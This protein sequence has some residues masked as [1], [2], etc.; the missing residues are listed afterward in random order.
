[1]KPRPRELDLLDQLW[2]LTDASR[3]HCEAILQDLMELSLPQFL[4]LRL[5]DESARVSTPSQV[6]RALGC[7]RA[8]ASE[9]LATLVKRGCVSRFRNANDGRRIW[10]VRT[11]HGADDAERGDEQLAADACDFFAAVDDAEKDLLF[12]LLEKIRIPR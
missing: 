9:L 5:V 7:S 12:G 4:A 6:A 8:N 10:L 11:I 3:A 1:M 2:R